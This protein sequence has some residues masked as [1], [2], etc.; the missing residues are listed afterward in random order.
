MQTKVASF[1]DGTIPESVQNYQ[2]EAVFNSALSELREYSRYDSVEQTE[3][4]PDH[5][6]GNP[7]FI[8]KAL[9][10]NKDTAW[11]LEAILRRLNNNL[12]KNE[13]IAL[14][15]VK[16]DW[17]LAKW[18]C[19]NKFPL[20]ENRTYFLEQ[21]SQ[22]AD[23]HVLGCA[24]FSPQENKELL[25]EANRRRSEALRDHP[26]L[27]KDKKFILDTVRQDFHALQ[28]VDVSLL[29]DAK[30]MLEAAKQN[31]G[32]LEY[33]HPSLRE[34]AEF[35]LEAATQN[36]DA[37]A[38]AADNLRGNSKFMLK[39]AKQNIDA[40]KYANDSLI[41]NP[42]FMLKAAGQNVDALAFAAD[43]LRGNSRFMLKAAKQNIDALK[44]ANDSLIRDPKFMLKADKL[45][46]RM[47]LQ[48]P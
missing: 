19:S 47:S 22:G 21:L 2:P 6:W 23:A 37:L 4:I 20:N 31:V 26:R 45:K 16:I 7:E 18:F 27:Q 13:T 12:R 14:A 33:A 36:V 32:A 43:N 8:L 11:K 46:K 40:L 38:F 17:E 48:Y 1:S 9:E 29:K 25:Q 5:L 28:Y 10:Q 15:A 44:Y 34:N 24:S 42:K 39:A 41:R 35:M 30:F 3:N